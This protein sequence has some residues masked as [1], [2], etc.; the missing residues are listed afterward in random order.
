[1]VKF[2]EAVI[3]SKIEPAKNC[4]YTPLRN[5]KPVKA[6]LLLQF[7]KLIRTKLSHKLQY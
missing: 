1:M 4:T 7:E 2:M 6:A 5:G 3:Y